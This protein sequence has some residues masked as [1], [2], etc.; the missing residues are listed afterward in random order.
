MK[1]KQIIWGVWALLL[2]PSVGLAQ[3]VG[4][5]VAETKT[6][7]GAG[8]L[9]SPIHTRMLVGMEGNARSSNNGGILRQ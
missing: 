1:A 2:F 4:K 6:P 8:S 5:P 3:D 9:W 7:V